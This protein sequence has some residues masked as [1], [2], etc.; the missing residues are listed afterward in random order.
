MAPNQVVRVIDWVRQRVHQ[1]VQMV[2]SLIQVPRL[3]SVHQILQQILP[4]SHQLAMEM[5]RE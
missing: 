2:A 5:H 3:D 1:L 4:K